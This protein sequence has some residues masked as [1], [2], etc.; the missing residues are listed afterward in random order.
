MILGTQKVLD[1]CSP[2]LLFLVWLYSVGASLEP[3]SPDTQA[4]D[5]LYSIAFIYCGVIVAYNSFQNL[6]FPG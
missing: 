5:S 4:L 6:A 1:G 2:L 3:S